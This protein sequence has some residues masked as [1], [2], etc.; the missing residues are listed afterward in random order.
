MGEEE[1]R[2]RAKFKTPNELL[3]QSRQ[4]QVRRDKMKYKGV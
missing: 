4:E 3:E 1:I 2:E